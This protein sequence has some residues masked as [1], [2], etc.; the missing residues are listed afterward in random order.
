M[1]AGIMWMYRRPACPICNDREPD[2]FEFAGNALRIPQGQRLREAKGSFH[3]NRP[4]RDYFIR[5]YAAEATNYSLA[6][7]T[8][9]QAEGKS[10]IIR[11]SE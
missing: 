5:K 2:D 3:K 7:R 1:A 9:F 10:S 8:G 4:Y 11:G 6:L